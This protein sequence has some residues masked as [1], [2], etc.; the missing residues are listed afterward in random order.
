MTTQQAYESHVWVGRVQP[1]TV[2]GPEEHFRICDRCGCQDL[3]D[4]AE[5]DWLEY[6]ECEPEPDGR[7]R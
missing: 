3:G 1:G 6:H 4:P 5:F 7:T 2:H